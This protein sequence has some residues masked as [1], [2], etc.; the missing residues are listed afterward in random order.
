MQ[1][2]HAAL[3]SRAQWPATTRPYDVR[4]VNS[5]PEVGGRQH[6]RRARPASSVSRSPAWPRS[7]RASRPRSAARR[8]PSRTRDPAARAAP[9]SASV[10]PPTWPSA[11]AAAAA[12][13]SQRSRSSADEPRDE[14]RAALVAQMRDPSARDRAAG[15]GAHLEVR[16]GQRR[17]QR[18]FHLRR[19]RRR[20]G[21][22]AVSALR[23]MNPTC[24]KSPPNSRLYQGAGAPVGQQRER[25]A[26]AS[27]A[28][29]AGRG[30]SRPG[31]ALPRTAAP[32]A[33]RPG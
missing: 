22:M 28:P 32:A 24:S 31:C 3:L 20:G 8:A 17:G 1:V 9:G 25:P 2:N 21:A 29:A 26:A 23:R 18:I 30:A 27:R 19:H 16:I 11:S 5:G 6:E 33:T 7:T 4:M 14:A 12:T 13:S 10:A 15:F